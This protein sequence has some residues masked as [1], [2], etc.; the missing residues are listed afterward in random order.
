MSCSCEVKNLETVFKSKYR[1]LLF[2]VF[3]IIFASGLTSFNK[4]KKIQELGAAIR[5]LENSVQTIKSK[6]S[7]YME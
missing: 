5:K 7:A 6:N 4:D 3:L 2:L 1:R